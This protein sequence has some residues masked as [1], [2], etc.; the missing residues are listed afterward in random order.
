[1]NISANDVG[2]ED[3]HPTSCC[4]DFFVVS[5]VMIHSVIPDCSF[6]GAWR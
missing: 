5:K 2:G 6:Y 3:F 1:M 4:L